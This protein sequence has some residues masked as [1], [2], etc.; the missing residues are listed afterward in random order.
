[1]R[2]T[3]LAQWEYAP[4]HRFMRAVAWD[5]IISVPLTY[6][7]Q[8]LGTLSTFL[9]PEHAPS[10]EDVRFLQ[11]IAD[12]A[13]IAVENARLLTEAQDKAALQERQKLARDLHD[14]VSQALYGIALGARTARTLLDRDP[15][16]AADPLDYVLTLADAGL[17]EMRALIFELRPESLQTEGLVAALEKQ[18]ASL[19]ARHGLVVTT[20]FCPEPDIPLD[21]KEA[22]YRIAQEALNNTVKHARAAAVEVELTCADDR[23]QLRIRDNGVGFDPTASFPG[24]FGLRGMQERVAKHGGRVTVESTPGEGTTVA[25]EVPVARSDAAPLPAHM[26]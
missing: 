12:Q 14:S 8:P 26:Q 17:A 20:R 4:L 19:R 10:D 3:V 18:M 21:I 15:S 11:T 22:L 5:T 9:R 23:V 7:G 2:A 24:H 13:A 25:V 6:R 16:R 1:V